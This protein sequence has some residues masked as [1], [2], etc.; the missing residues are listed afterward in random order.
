[1]PQVEEEWKTVKKTDR[2]RVMRRRGR[3]N[4]HH[5][6]MGHSS[7]TSPLIEDYLQL[8]QVIERCMTDV[9]QTRIYQDVLLRLKEENLRLQHL[10]C[11]GIGSFSASSTTHYS[12]SMWQIAFA[13]SLV[14][15]STTVK[16]KEITLSYFDPCMSTIEERFL[17]ER[18]INVLTTNERGKHFFQQDGPVLFFMPHCPKLLYENV[19]WSHWLRLRQ[20]AIIGNS[21]INHAEALLSG[22]GGGDDRQPCPCLKHLVPFI[23]EVKLEASKL[24]VQEAA[25]NFNGAF[26][27]TYLTTFARN[28]AWPDRPEASDCSDGDG[29]LI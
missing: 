24:D 23:E 7:V 27:D 14:M 19:A 25:G 21:L 10:V 6:A 8:E 3:G 11:Y 15:D 12:A 16:N 17:C 28:D 13:L 5:S 9:Q 20:I 4:G 26:N 1:M 18:H 2:K 29:E 22:G